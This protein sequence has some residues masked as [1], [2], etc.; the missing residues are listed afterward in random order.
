MRK[1]G[2]WVN[3]ATKARFTGSLVEYTVGRKTECRNA[4][5]STF[6]LKGETHYAAH[7]EGYSP[8]MG[9]GI[10]ERP[11][12]FGPDPY[13]LVCKKCGDESLEHPNDL[14]YMLRRK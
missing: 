12:P 13:V 2:A 11:T 14:K 6:M 9:P 10:C 3:R 7:V 8:T 1:R 5:C 4:R